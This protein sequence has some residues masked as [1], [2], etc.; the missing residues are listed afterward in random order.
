VTDSYSPFRPQA[1][2]RCTRPT[3]VGHCDGL[4]WRVDAN[5]LPAAHGALLTHYGTVTMLLE[6]RGTCLWPEPYDP[7]RHDLD[8]PNRW[9]VAPH[10][11]GS[12]HAQ[13]KEIA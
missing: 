5:A 3:F 6:Q 8:R 11:C 9:L 4:F 13:R 12:A 7:Y 2:P 1:C 10:V